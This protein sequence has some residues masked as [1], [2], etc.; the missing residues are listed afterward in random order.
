M[1]MPKQIILYNLAPHVTD[2]QFKEYVTKEK[3]PLMES[4][5]SVEKYELVKITD[6]NTGA[7]PFKYIGIMHVKDMKGL[8]ERDQKSQKYQEF[9]AKF[10]PMVTDLHSLFGEEIY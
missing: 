2:E 4:F 5:E 7:I 1:K 3:G 8:K 6:S 9:A 10:R